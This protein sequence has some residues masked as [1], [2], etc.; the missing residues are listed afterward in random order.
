MTLGCAG[1]QGTQKKKQHHAAG[2]TG[3][4]KKQW[5][6]PHLY[7]TFLRRNNS[8]KATQVIRNQ[9]GFTLIEL[10][11]VAV[12]LAIIAAIAV[13]IYQGYKQEAQAQE[14]YMTLTQMA[15]VCIGKAVKALETGGAVGVLT[16]PANGD[17][18]GYA[19]TN[20]CNTAGGVFTANGIAGSVTGETLNVT[21]VVAQASPFTPS[22]TWGG[23][24]K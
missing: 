8:M 22:K 5:H 3:W 21:V 6:G 17:Y 23:T 12:I 10:M 18:F 2:F 14:A 1:A 13:P 16:V 24:L 19:I 15:D 7:F 11:V 9:Q 4:Q 20:A